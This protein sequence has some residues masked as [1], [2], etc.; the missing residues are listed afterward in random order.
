MVVW[1]TFIA[2][3]NLNETKVFPPNWVYA[4]SR[5]Q[6][7]LA[8]GRQ[9]TYELHFLCPCD[10]NPVMPDVTILELPYLDMTKRHS[11]LNMKILWMYI[12]TEKKKENEFR[13]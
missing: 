11:V 10:R 12:Y 4:A 2:L 8:L 9:V 5:S 6:H 1:L 7:K 3:E 13:S